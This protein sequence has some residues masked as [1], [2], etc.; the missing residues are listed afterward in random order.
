MG[1]RRQVCQPSFLLWALRPFLLV[2]VLI[3]DCL[4]DPRNILGDS[5]VDAG[6]V[7][8]PA[9]EV[10]PGDDAVE[11]SIA[12]QGAP[13]VTLSGGERR[14]SCW[15]RT[16]AET[17]NCAERAEGWRRQ[18]QEYRETVGDGNTVRNR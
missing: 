14:S 6:P 12:D 3:L 18:R 17:G 13:G 10:S 2:S 7:G 1:G 11:S 16:K 8:L 4:S 5:G 15:G 9:W